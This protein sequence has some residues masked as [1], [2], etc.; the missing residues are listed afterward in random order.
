MSIQM[1]F[2]LVLILQGLP[3]INAALVK[4]QQKNVGFFHP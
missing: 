2:C 3:I 1:Q 4:N